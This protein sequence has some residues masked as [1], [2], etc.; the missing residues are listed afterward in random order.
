M[1]QA[2]SELTETLRPVFGDFLDPESVL[3]FLKIFGITY[4]HQFAQFN[5]EETPQGQIPDFAKDC[6]S[7]LRMEW[8]Y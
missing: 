7:W 1:P 2:T 3:Q 5:R 4:D 6:M 8:D